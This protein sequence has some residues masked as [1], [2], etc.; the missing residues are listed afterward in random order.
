MTK[1]SYV[2]VALFDRIAVGTSFS[3]RDWAAH[4]TLASNFTTDTRVDDLARAVRRTGALAE[5]LIVQF[6]ELAQFGPR[7]DVPVR[8]VHSERITALHYHL[9]DQLELLPGYAAEEPSYWRASPS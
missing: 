5:A 8:L 2:V 4:V 9:A 1:E 7:R 3:R 6:T